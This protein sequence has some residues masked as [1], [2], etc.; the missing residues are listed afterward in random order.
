MSIIWHDY[1]SGL[2]SYAQIGGYH[3]HVV[4]AVQWKAVIMHPLSISTGL[5]HYDGDLTGFA[6]KQAAQQAAE[7]WVAERP[8]EQL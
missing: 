6:S 8:L 5:C 4:R 1:D 2:S 7:A 3:V